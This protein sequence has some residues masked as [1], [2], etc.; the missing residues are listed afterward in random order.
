F[1]RT[2]VDMFA[3][4]HYQV[5]TDYLHKDG[6]KPYAEAG[7]VSLESIE[8]ALL[9]K[10]YVDIPMGEFWVRDLHPTPMYEEDVK[11]AVS[12]AHVYGKK[13][14]AAESFTGGNY[15]SPYT[16]KKIADYYMAKGLNRLV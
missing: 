5:I 3:E 6:L 7:G 4:N 2:L 8:D 9:N 16:L 10:K 13:I 14:V 11:G 12:A 1:R 15:E